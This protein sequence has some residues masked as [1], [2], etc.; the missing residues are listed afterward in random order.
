MRF[1]R[2][3][4]P[5]LTPE[6]AKEPKSDYNIQTEVK[7]KKFSAFSAE[8]KEYAIEPDQSLRFEDKSEF[9]VFEPKEEFSRIPF[10]PNIRLRL[11]EI[12]N[13]LAWRYLQ[14]FEPDVEAQSC[15]VAVNHKGITYHLFNAKRMPVGRMAVL[16]SQYL[17]GKHRPG[18]TKNSFMT[19]DKC[20]VVNVADPF[21]TGRK[22]QQKV[23]RH[24]TGY[25]GGLKEFSFKD[26]VEKRPERII[27]EAVMGMLP[28]NSL[29]KEILKKGLIL[30]REPY[31]NYAHVGLP[32]FTEPIPADINTAMGFDDISADNSVIKFQRGDIPEE[33]SHLP[34]DI[35]PSI[36]T[37]EMAKSKTHEYSRTD[38][39]RG[40]YMAKTP[41]GVKRYKSYK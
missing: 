27:E 3:L 5:N 31:H 9:S 23:Y 38:I 1:F 4:P 36:G 40:L 22:R 12:P 21:F 24:H 33:L 34:V 7:K 15:Y 26:V 19:T 16:I 20:I 17:R 8:P 32:Q 6:G 11:P 39:M 37:P 13:S 2:R 25:P 41:K 35:D 28:K 29:R 30:I 14:G 18:Y 10:D